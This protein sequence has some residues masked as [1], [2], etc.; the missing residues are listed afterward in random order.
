MLEAGDRVTIQTGGGGGYGD[1]RRRDRARGRTDVL[2]GY[3]SADAAR[4]VYGL[5]AVRA[6]RASQVAR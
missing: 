3:V 5:D 6:C 2:R 4:E 1:P